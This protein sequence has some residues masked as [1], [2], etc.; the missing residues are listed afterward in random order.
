MGFFFCS[1]PR[2]TMY[3]IGIIQ[4]QLICLINDGSTSVWSI[5]EVDNFIFGQPTIEWSLECFE[6]DW[7]FKWNLLQHLST[8]INIKCPRYLPFRTVDGIV[9][10]CNNNEVPL[11]F[12]NLMTS[13]SVPTNITNVSILQNS[14]LRF[15][16]QD[17]CNDLI[18]NGNVF[19]LLPNMDFVDGIP[20]LGIDL[21][22]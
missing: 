22:A 8:Y 14:G 1:N 19:P 7:G 20:P 10:M 15:P 6:D 12:Y 9:L 17:H 16:F 21:L 2:H 18:E 11:M 4:N 13:S 5:E 3:V